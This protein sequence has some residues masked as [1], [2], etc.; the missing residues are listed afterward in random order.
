MSAYLPHTDGLQDTYLVSS[1]MGTVH[2]TNKRT[3]CIKAKNCNW[4]II[5][6]NKTPSSLLFNYLFLLFA[7]FYYN[8]F[9]CSSFSANLPSIFKHYLVLLSLIS[10]LVILRKHYLFCINILNC[11][12][13]T[14]LFG[15]LVVVVEIFS[16]LLLVFGCVMFRPM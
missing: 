4:K 16:W 8:W 14:F 12:S 2:K 1:G 6:R 11:K 10:F 5:A 13:L 3:H 15:K 9:L 7:S